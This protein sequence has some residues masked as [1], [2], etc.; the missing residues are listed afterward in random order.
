MPR[1]LREQTTSD[2]RRGNGSGVNPQP[3]VGS[4]ILISDWLV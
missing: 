4:S 3:Y 1:E 2:D